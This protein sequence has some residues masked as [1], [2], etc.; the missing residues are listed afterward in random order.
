MESAESQQWF[1]RKHDD[2]TVFGPLPFEQLA[3]WAAAAQIA[4]HDT[5]STDQQTWLKAPMLTALGMD[6]L[7]E[8]TS[9]RYYGPTTV[10]AVFEFLRL[11]EITPE[12]FAINTCDGSRRQIA[13][14]EPPIGDFEQADLAS[15]APQPAGMSVNFEERIR[16][17]EQSLAE[18]RR[19]LR[20]SEVRYRELESRYRE[21]LAQTGSDG[22]LRP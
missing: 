10:G 2:G 11:G 18:E 20:D 1:L 21:L 6:W 12:T 7:V 5:V 19:A 16:D 13:Q 4:P 8:L 17:L 3:R 14:L 15:A 9:E 22:T